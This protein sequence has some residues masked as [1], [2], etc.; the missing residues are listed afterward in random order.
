[1]MKLTGLSGVSQAIARSGAMF[2]ITG[3]LLAVSA[4]S[5]AQQPPRGKPPQEALEACVAK[6]VGDQCQIQ[7]QGQ[8][9][10]IPGQC[11][12]PPEG[13]PGPGAS[14]DAPADGGEGLACLPEGA[15]PP[16]GP[17]ER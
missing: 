2:A 8:Q 17:A 14:G 12:A 6:Q 11:I 5:A 1:M 15:K 13:G 9:D 4:V 10:L 7:V 16:G 3:A